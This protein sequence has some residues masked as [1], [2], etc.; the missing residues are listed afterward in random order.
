MRVARHLCERCSLNWPPLLPRRI[1]SPRLGIL[2]GRDLR[3]NSGSCPPP[4]GRKRVDHPEPDLDL[5]NYHRCD[6]R[7]RR[8]NKPNSADYLRQYPGNVDKLGRHNR[9]V[10]DFVVDRSP[11]ATRRTRR[12]QSPTGNPARPHH[13]PPH[14]NRDRDKQRKRVTYANTDRAYIGLDPNN[15]GNRDRPNIPDPALDLGNY[16]GNNRDRD[17][18]RS[19]QRHPNPDRDHLDVNPLDLRDRLRPD[20]PDASG[21]L[22]DRPDDYSDRNVRRKRLGD[23]YPDRDYLDVCPNDLG[24]GNGTHLTDAS[25]DLNVDRCSYNRSKW[26]NVTSSAERARS[27]TDNQLD[28][29][30]PS[31]PQSDRDLRHGPIARSRPRPPRRTP[32]LHNP[33]G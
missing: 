7:R 28:R 3:E 4:I 5:G 30:R 25:G 29:N 15:L 32:Q 13:V 31:S 1:L 26:H 33:A 14:N 12:R 24:N 2:N 20:R 23:R 10:P 18:R 16:P 17:R 27:Y 19:W 8:N 22:G 9:T 11:T 6:V 21:D